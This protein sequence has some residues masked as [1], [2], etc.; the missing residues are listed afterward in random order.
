MQT[1]L[2]LHFFFRTLDLI[3]NV[4]AISGPSRHECSSL[5]LFYIYRPQFVPNWKPTQQ[6]LQRCPDREGVEERCAN[7]R[8]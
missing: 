6:Q 8:A 1:K 2:D 3:L 5:P 7:G 4:Y